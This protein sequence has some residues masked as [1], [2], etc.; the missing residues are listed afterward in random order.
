[1]KT[2]SIISIIYGVLGVI[3]GTMILAVMQVQQSF[4]EHFPWPPEVNQ[5]I[6][7]PAL[8]SALHSFW[9]Y[10]MPFVVVIAIIYIVSGILGLSDKPQAIAFGLLAA[11]FNI[12]WFV[13]FVIIL[14]VE[15]IPAINTGDF[16]P[17][18]LFQV[19]VFFGLVFDAVFYCS[20]PVFLL[21]YL[22]KQ[23]QKT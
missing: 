23:R 6:D 8:I 10:L 3:W 21:I 19:F 9:S 17:E 5:V 12:I 18:K 14:Q 7:M 1:M 15:L 16:F 2:V 4:L 20:Y 13:A 22:N 11:V